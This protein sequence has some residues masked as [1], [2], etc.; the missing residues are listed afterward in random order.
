MEQLKAYVGEKIAKYVSLSHNEKSNNSIAKDNSNKQFEIKLTGENIL[1]H[2]GD[3][4]DSVPTIYRKQKE[5]DKVYVLYDNNLIV[6]SDD[7]ILVTQLGYYKHSDGQ[8]FRTVT[9]PK[10]TIE[11]SEN[12]PLKINSLHE[13]FKDL[14]SKEVANLNSWDL[15]KY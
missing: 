6:D 3:I 4:K 8:T 1:L 15:K 7:K 2:F 9:V 12:P 10:N 5:T 14:S 13:A 11:V